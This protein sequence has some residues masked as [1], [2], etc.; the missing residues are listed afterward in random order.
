MIGATPE[1]KLLNLIRKD[2]AKAKIGKDLRIFTKVNVLL[3][4]L[5]VIVAIVFL[6]DIFVFK[7]KPSE[8]YVLDSQVAVPQAQPAV[9][10]AEEENP[11]EQANIDKNVSI[12]K[13]SREEIM[14]QYNLLGIITGDNNQAIIEDKALRKT[15]FLYK[16]DSLGE[17]KV[18]DIRNS[19]VIL[20]YKGE[21]IELNI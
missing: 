16:G 18:Y 5:I 11:M 21:K 19:A 15:F 20:E 9:D 13:V 2:Q 14:G 12:R 6:L 7:G 1:E 10:E 8:E 17:L 4:G 3:M